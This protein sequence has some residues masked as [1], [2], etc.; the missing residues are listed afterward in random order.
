MKIFWEEITKG[1]LLPCYIMYGEESYLIRQYENRL[2]EL[3]KDGISEDMNISVF[4]GDVEIGTVMETLETFPF[5]AEKRLVIV[6]DSKLFKATKKSDSEQMANFIAKIP[7]TS[8]LVFIE[9][10]MDKRTKLYKAV[11]KKGKAIEFKAPQEK[12]LISW[13]KKCF[14]KHG[15]TIESNNAIH[16]LR[17]TAFSMER[18]N[19][20]IEKLSSYKV[21]GE[22]TAEDIDNLCTKTL[23][24]KIFDLMDSI[25]NRKT[26]KA[27]SLYNDMIFLREAPMMIFSMII[28]Q[29]RL[30]LQVKIL[31]NTGKTPSEISGILG[32]REFIVKQSLN[33]CRNFTEEV[34]KRAME[35]CIETDVAIKTGKVKDVLGVEMIIIKYSN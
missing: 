25:S 19:G 23:E 5:F 16:L 10:E 27:M 29:F 11:D 34:L 24:S 9:T 13:V 3:F 1:Q 20:E 6:K 8:H 2:K 17:Y 35:D 7:P 4:Q 26:S 15:L 30:M 28:R 22:I 14:K 32:Q 12:E 33:Q 21:S 18:T 31:A